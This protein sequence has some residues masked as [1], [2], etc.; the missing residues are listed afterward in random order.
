SGDTGAYPNSSIVSEW[1]AAHY[2]IYPI[3][4]SRKNNDSEHLSLR[5]T[6][7][8]KDHP[9]ELNPKY[10]YVEDIKSKQQYPAQSI[11]I[12]NQGKLQGFNHYVYKMNFSIKNHEINEFELNIEQDIFGCNIKPIHYHKNTNTEYKNRMPRTGK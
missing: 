3:W 4:F 2:F 5:I 8:T 12:I 11:E 1:T 9:H 7:K 6:F 10:I